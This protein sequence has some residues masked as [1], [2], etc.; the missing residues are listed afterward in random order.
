MGLRRSVANVV[1][2][3]LLDLASAEDADAETVA[4]CSEF[5]AAAFAFLAVSLISLGLNAFGYFR[6]VLVCPRRRNRSE[7]SPATG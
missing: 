2:L 5:G 1:L 7:R 6:Q 4:T 3:L